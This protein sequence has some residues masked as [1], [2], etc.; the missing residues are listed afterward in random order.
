VKRRLILCGVVALQETKDA[1][2]G[3]L[4]GLTTAGDFLAVVFSSI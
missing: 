4:R 2:R 3:D 1:D